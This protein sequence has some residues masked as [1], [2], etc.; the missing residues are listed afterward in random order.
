MRTLFR[1]ML[2]TITSLA[3][4]VAL[5]PTPAL[6]EALDGSSGDGAASMEWKF[7]QSGTNRDSTGEN[8]QDST[9]NR[10][11]TGQN[12]SA[13]RTD[14]STSAEDDAGASPEQTSAPT[15]QDDSSSS[16]P[17]ESDSKNAASADVQAQEPELAYAA[18]VQNIGWQE[19][20]SAGEVVGTT[21]KGLRMEALRLSLGSM[22]DG[23][24]IRVSAHVQNIGWQDWKSS[25]DSE[26]GYAIAGTTGKGL[27][28]EA[29]K[30][31]LDGPVASRYDIWYRVHVQDKGW[32]GWTNDGLMAGTTGLGKRIEAA[33]VMLVEKGADA[34]G[35]I[36]G[37]SE[38][39][40]EQQP[41]VSYRSHVQNMGW[42]GWFSDGKTA[43]TTGMGLA[44]EALDARLTGLDGAVQVDSHVQD[45][46]WQGYRQT[47]D[48]I[49]SG[50]TGQSKRVEAIRARLTGEVAQTH[51]LWYR[52]HV[53]NL[54]WLD[55][56]K[57]GNDSSDGAIAGT[58]G[59][60]LR[61]E[62]VQF[63]LTDKGAA[64]PGDTS[65]PYV[66]APTL[67]Y[68]AHV[69][70][71][72]WQGWVGS[73]AVAGT[74]GRGL[75]A[76]ALR[77]NASGVGQTGEVQI[78]AHVQDIGWQ[79]WKSQ[80]DVAGTIGQGRRLEAVRIQLT[81]S[82]AQTCDVWYRV[83]IERLGWMGW[84][85]NGGYAGTTG[86]SARIEA[87]QI[88]VTPKDS[89]V[90]G[91][92]WRSYT[93]DRGLFM[94]D[95][96]MY[97]RAQNYGSRTNWLLMVN[98]GACRVGIFMRS[99]SGWSLYDYILCSDGQYS[100]PTVH[101]VFSV[102]AKGYSF[103]GGDHTCYYYTQF[104]GNYLFHSVLYHRGTYGVLDGRLGMHISQGCVRLDINKAKWIHDNIPTGTTVV[105]YN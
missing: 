21:G 71:I 17:T 32:M 52:V 101:G 29:V 45:L 99:G 81:G 48:S 89:V 76:E 23:S 38:T 87:V 20:V 37:S 68:Q 51:D 105:V 18:H 6:A 78:S 82:M 75:R 88:M 9:S 42:Q 25:A 100:T 33:Q 12:T 34:P 16:T 77:A 104:Y 50:T 27:R 30:I 66:A 83:H 95:A 57:A 86:C 85:R 7:V 84:T 35:S 46:G 97:Y 90:P 22:T 62:A 47:S 63:K 53:K 49:V 92:T 19:N 56:A 26:D 102:G 73:G 41:S 44:V 61:V 94:G 43:G 60:A 24:S 103:S 3:M 10:D 74:T 93:A 36:S 79:N 70:N 96:D 14:V 69:Q 28:V 1:G 98:Y 80:G 67:T 40:I 65:R 55:W 39:G 58:T 8:G 64:A 2:A 13:T 11:V 4:C 54:G 5:V 15:N 31:K 59:L 91:S 72:G